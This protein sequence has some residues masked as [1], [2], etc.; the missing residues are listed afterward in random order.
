MSRSLSGSSGRAKTQSGGAKLDLS[1]REDEVRDG[2]GLDRNQ[3]GLAEEEVAKIWERE[4]A[5][6]QRVRE[7][8]AAK[9][10]DNLVETFR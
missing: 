4:E 9:N 3:K 5:K 1:V 7:K 2:L 10:T 8:A 6:V